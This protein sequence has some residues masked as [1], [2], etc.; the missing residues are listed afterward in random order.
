M[1]GTWVHKGSNKITITAGGSA[2]S[3]VLSR[4]WNT[5]AGSFAIT[6]SGQ[7]ADGGSIWGVRT[8]D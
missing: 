4:Q 3:G 8:G 2:F 6:F 7:S 5:N 1:T